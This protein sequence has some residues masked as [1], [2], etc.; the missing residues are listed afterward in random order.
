MRLDGK[1]VLVTGGGTG[2]GRACAARLA[3]DGALVTICGRTESR[4]HEAAASIDPSVK[5]VVA[6]VTVE[7]DVARA[8]EAAS[9]AEGTLHGVVA[10][11]GGAGPIV[12]YHLQDT[13]GYESV[14][15]LN[16]LGTMLCI[17]HAVPRLVAA[18][19]GSFVGMSSIAGHV[20]HPYF[21]AYTVSKAGIQEMMRNAADEYGAAGVRFNAVQPGFT[22]TELMEIIPRD[23]AVY[24]SYLRN[25]PMGG[26]AEPADVADVVAFLIGPDSRWVTGQMIAVDGGHHLRAGPDFSSL[27]GLTTDQLL[28]RGPS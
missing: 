2:I 1:A 9:T 15:K 16:I 11:A 3:A 8:V 19:G 14:L 21:G 27:L 18:G 24:E 7:A 22:T 10:N 25:T 28:A 12:P 20:T 26:V 23:G 4:L 5:V 13:A 6:D 17:K